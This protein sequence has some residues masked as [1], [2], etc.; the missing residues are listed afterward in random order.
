[1]NYNHNT[2]KKEGKHSKNLLNLLTAQLR[3]TIQTHI[4][5]E[6]ILACSFFQIFSDDFINQLC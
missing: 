5:K 3:E 1:M 4:Y 2:A 6:V